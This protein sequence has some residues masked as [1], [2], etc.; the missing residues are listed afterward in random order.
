MATNARVFVLQLSALGFLSRVVQILAILSLLSLNDYFT[1]P[2]QIPSLLPIGLLIVI[3]LI[4][5]AAADSVSLSIIS[6]LTERL[7]RIG[8]VYGSGSFSSATRGSFKENIYYLRTVFLPLLT[9]VVPA[10]LLVIVLALNTPYLFLVTIVQSFANSLL[11]NY[12]NRKAATSSSTNK[13]DYE[14]SL[15]RTETSKSHFYRYIN[16]NGG[17]RIRNEASR[18]ETGLSNLYFSRKKDALRTSNLV[19]RGIILILSA[20]LSI[21]KLSSLSDVVGFFILNNTLR[22][23]IIALAE[24]CWPA[25]RYLTL[26][27]AFTM[28]DV[29]LRDEDELL[30][31]TKVQKQKQDQKRIA[32]DRR[33]SEPLELKPYLR[34][35]E[36]KLEQCRPT[37][38]NLFMGVTGRIELFAIN[39]IVINGTNLPARVSAF[40]NDQDG[41]LLEANAQGAAVCGQVKIDSFFWRN[42]PIANPNQTRIISVRLVNHFDPTHHAR[43]NSLIA[44]YDLESFYLP[45]DCPTY[46]LSDLSRKEIQ[47][48]R[49]LIV[50]LDTI[51]DPHVLWLLPFVLDVFEDE[52]IQT[53]ID[54]YSR[55]RSDNQRSVF[56]MS[57]TLGFEN[58]MHGYYQVSTTS[59][60]PV[61]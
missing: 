61:P 24:Y 46:A 47:K 21:Y 45:L 54:F 50:I 59:L 48:M 12:F 5:V 23:A 40:C 31:Q 19:F 39:I 43:I 60:E 27:Q 56:L 57:R 52:Q 53:L 26:K 9:T 38:R 22:S 36:F 29:A 18:D 30:N 13:K 6:Q 41:N 15:L 16:N 44:A 2:S 49:S 25:C 33:M 51:I 7:T 1:T 4:L 42:L 17:S 8:S 28:I 3:L 20:I 32:F 14:S 58:K 10:P 35:K 55:E 11:I 34:L 37:Q